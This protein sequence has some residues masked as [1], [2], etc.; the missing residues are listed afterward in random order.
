MKKKYGQLVNE[1]FEAL[2]TF[3]PMTRVEICQQLGYTKD[4]ISA[5]V[6][7]M[8]TTTKERPQRLYIKAYVYDHEGSKRYPRAVYA[9]GDLPNAR[10]PKSDENANKRRYHAAKRARYTM[11]SVFNMGLTRLQIKAQTGANI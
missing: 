10:K 9:V 1:I 6:S 2:T 11:N 8:A 7:R 4:Q 3:G 5:V